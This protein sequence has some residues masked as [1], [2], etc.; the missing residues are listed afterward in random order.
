MERE[1]LE[2]GISMGLS[3]RELAKELNTSQSNVRHWLRKYGLRTQIEGR[4]N[5]RG[6]QPVKVHTQCRI[7]HREMGSNP[8]NQAKCNSC[9]TTL[10]RTRV[11]MAAVNLLGGK[12]VK[13]GYNEH[14]AALEF[15]HADD[16]KEFTI[17]GVLHKSWSVI[18]QEV[19]KCTLLCAICHRIEHSHR[20]N[21]AMIIEAL[22]YRGT[23]LKLV[24]GR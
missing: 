13:C 16:N 24:E 15:H 18:R 20:Y 3:Q 4:G 23:K 7:C 2:Q 6:Y 1:L 11:K 19:L 10:R 9:I 22:A 21:D 17:G 8:R 5:G 14:Y 12:C